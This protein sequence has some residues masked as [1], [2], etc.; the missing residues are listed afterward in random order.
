M[1]APRKFTTAQIASAIVALATVLCGG[2]Y[3]VATPS[4]AKTSD[5]GTQLILEKIQELSID[6]KGTRS[7]LE[8]IK[9]KMKIDSVST[10]YKQKEAD[11]AY[12]L[13]KKV[14]LQVDNLRRSSKPLYSCED[15]FQ[16]NL[17]SRQKD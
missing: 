16:S 11:T 2:S 8:Q 3:V 12:A 9:E 14:S 4:E 17:A 6:V 7:D 5:V 13:I 1:P 15:M 10:Y